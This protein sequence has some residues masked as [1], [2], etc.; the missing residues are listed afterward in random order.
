[1]DFKNVFHKL[2]KHNPLIM[3]APNAVRCIG[4]WA[5]DLKCV[6]FIYNFLCR[7]N[8]VEAKKRE[9]ARWKKIIP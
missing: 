3:L 7:R 1:M 5:M 6:T 9:A 8:E 2:L 4:E